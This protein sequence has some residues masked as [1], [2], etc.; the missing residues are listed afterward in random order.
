MKINSKAA[1]ISDMRISYEEGELDEKHMPLDPLSKFQDWFS[2]AREDPRIIE[3]NAMT[4]AT[5]N[6]KGQPSSR[7]V[8]LKGF[9][10]TGFKLFTNYDSRKGTDLKKNKSA[11]L[12]FFWEPLQRQVCRIMDE[13]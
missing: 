12:C 2:E 5:V 9:D 11:A 8:L 1:P 4:L 3:A 13:L 6:E 10:S 7:V